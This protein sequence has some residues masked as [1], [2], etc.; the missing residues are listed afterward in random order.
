MQDR[1]KHP[2]VLVFE[3]GQVR[4][5]ASARTCV[6]KDTSD[7]GAALHITSFNE[8]PDQFTLS[9]RN[10]AARECKVV[11]KRRAAFGVRFLNG[12]P[13]GVSDLKSSP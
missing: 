12:A 4:F 3:V 10:A 7:G 9:R 5:G 11:W 8:V 13:L 6:V 2:R 1:R